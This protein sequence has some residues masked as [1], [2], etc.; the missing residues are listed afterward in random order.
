[1]IIECVAVNAKRINQE[2]KNFLDF[3]IGLRFCLNYIVITWERTS[4]EY[5]TVYAKR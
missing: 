3:F 5:L 1:M 4:I 2:Q